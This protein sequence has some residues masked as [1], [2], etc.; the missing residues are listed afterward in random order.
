[1]LRHSLKYERTIG[2]YH[3]LKAPK[4]IESEKEYE[5]CSGAPVFDTTGKFIGVL[6]SVNAG[7][8]MMFVFDISQILRL[9]DYAVAAGQA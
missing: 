8:Q 1:M 5:G 6:S 4:V 2:R 9:I 7:S 3:L